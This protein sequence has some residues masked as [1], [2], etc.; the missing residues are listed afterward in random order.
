[1]TLGVLIADDQTLL[2]SSFRLL[3]EA[4]ADIAVLGEAANGSEAVALAQELHPD[5][6][7]M[8]VRMPGVDGIEAT[9]RIA[10]EP[11]TADVKVLILTTFDLDEY[12]YG[13]LRAGA[14][15]FVLKEISPEDLLSAIRVVAAGD[16]LLAPGVTRRL[17]AE[18]AQQSTREAQPVSPKL[19][20]LTDREREVLGL[21]AR[22]LSNAEI[23]DSLHMSP[24]TAKTHVS[25][26]LTK[27]GMRDRA[28]LVVFAYESG[29]AHPGWQG[30]VTANES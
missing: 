12:V 20:M 29:L 28:Q 23:A 26:L 21:V 4:E 14:S 24:G 9:R 8:D 25:R 30:S 18:F 19:D 6:V 7:L 16:A 5:V 11:R 1:M 2:R 15:G 10:N 13:A 3:I 22:G 27:L 17:I